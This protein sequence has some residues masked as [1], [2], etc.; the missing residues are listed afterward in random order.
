MRRAPQCGK[1]CTAKAKQTRRLFCSMGHINHIVRGKVLP[2][3]VR[4]EHRLRKVHGGTSRCCHQYGCSADVS[5]GRFG[6]ADV[7]SSTN[8]QRWCLGLGPERPSPH[9]TPIPLLLVLGV[10]GNGHLGEFFPR[11]SVPK[12]SLLP[13]SLPSPWQKGPGT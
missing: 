6:G 11:R 7:C 5:P 4:T 10:I 12:V 2:R 13:R 1:G 3:V 8:R 9:R